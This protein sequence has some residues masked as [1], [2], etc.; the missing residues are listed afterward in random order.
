MNFSLTGYDSIPTDGSGRIL[1]TDI[2]LNG[3][4]N[5]DALICRSEISISG[6]T[7]TSDWYSHPTQMSTDEDDRIVSPP[8]DR[9]WKRNRGR[10]SEG[11]RLVRLRRVSATAEEGVLTCDI[12]GDINTPRS[13][14]IYYSS[15][16]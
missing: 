5:E 11:H 14:G 4:N 9:G 12:P 8:A 1:I 2:N 10:Y 16:S 13:V 7:S 15:E 6:N 3:D